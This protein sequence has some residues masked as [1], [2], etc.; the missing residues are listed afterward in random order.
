MGTRERMGE[1]LT[2]RV[3]EGGVAFY[4]GR[5]LKLPR[6]AVRDGDQIPHLLGRCQYISVLIREAAK[7][8]GKQGKKELVVACGLLRERERGKQS[9]YYG[10]NIWRGLR[11]DARPVAQVGVLVRLDRVVPRGVEVVVD[12]VRVR[13]DQ[14]GVH[15][16]GEVVPDRQADPVLLADHGRPVGGV[17]H[18]GELVGR[19]DAT[20]VLALARQLLCPL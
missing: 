10:S 9:T 12:D 14:V 18:D 5:P 6:G 8:E 2:G 20:C 11:E 15:L 17:L 1:G 3:G 4:A 16:L 19:P 13:D 7:R